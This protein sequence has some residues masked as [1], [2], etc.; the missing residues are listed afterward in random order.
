V[1]R[2]LSLF[3][4]ALFLLVLPVLTTA[5]ETPTPSPHLKQ[6]TADEY[7]T[8]IDEII[9]KAETNYMEG[10][11]QNQMEA[12]AELAAIFDEVNW[13]YLDQGELSYEQ[14][15]RLMQALPVGKSVGGYSELR[16]VPIEA[17]ERW[18]PALI[19]RWLAAN[20]DVLSPS[21]S[22]GVSHINFDE[23]DIVIT[24][25]YTG[26]F[27]D[28]IESAINLSSRYIAV[29]NSDR[30]WVVPPL[31]ESIDSDLLI[32]DDLNTDGM[33]DFAYLHTIHDGNS[34]NMGDLVVVSWTG[35]KFDILTSLRYSQAPHTMNYS[36]QFLNIDEDPQIEV[37]QNQRMYDTF[38]CNS[39]HVT[40]FD[41]DEEQQLKPNSK[42]V[43]LP[44]GFHCLLRKAEEAVW[45]G[46]YI[47]AIEVYQQ[48]LSFPTE[49]TA[50]FEFAQMRLA[51]AYLFTGDAEKADQI[52]NSLTPTEGSL[53]EVAQ[54]AYQVDHRPLAVCQA[55]YNAAIADQS[56]IWDV[57]L[58]T[59]YEVDGGFYG[60]GSY[61]PWIDVP[62][63][64]CDL[65]G[66]IRASIAD[67]NFPTTESPLEKL[68]SLGLKL[69]GAGSADFDQDGDEEW[70]VW[71]D[72]IGLSS[73]L[74]VPDG[75]FY[76]LNPSPDAENVLEPSASI[77][78]P[79]QYNQYSVM[80]LPD[81]LG[82]ALVNIDFAD[83]PYSPILCVF[84]G[85]GPVV[86]CEEYDRSL[87]RS[88]GNLTLFRV[89]NGQF[90]KF[91]SAPVCSLQPMGDSV[92]AGD[93]ISGVE[94]FTAGYGFS[95][96]DSAY[97]Y[98]LYT[99]KDVPYHWDSELKTFIP[100]LPPT[101]T[102]TPFPTPTYVPETPP[103]QRGYEFG[104]FTFPDVRRAFQEN[105]YSLVDAIAES[106]LTNDDGS[107]PNLTLAYRYYRA[108][109]LE[110]QGNLEAALEEYQLIFETAPD[111]AWG[112]L[113]GIHITIN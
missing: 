19:E 25:A 83:D 92:F 2:K 104:A 9:A 41:W 87:P 50:R 95:Q 55:L 86:T 36:W 68:E 84:C 29:S 54:Q 63:A 77:R 110:A 21:A 93:V 8:R 27:L 35:E 38:D 111:S 67:T 53:A 58:G 26:Y 47:E 89:E 33:P 22:S 43:L 64:S 108:L 44:A 91:F 105:D 69:G 78:P 70:L 112:M 94:G 106:A 28:V 49:D 37:I 32:A 12:I 56:P 66:W 57:S 30:E 72:S 20:P 46:N 103:E 14:M 1:F 98:G 51:L 99:V 4:F 101:P 11:Y 6:P 85:G 39:I 65:H 109:S 15:G 81:G 88:S 71:I 16:W 74:F 40:A 76:I 31:P 97:D 3:L 62:N 24:P 45:A 100:Q 73:I 48:A 107:D 90:V 52:F 80:T 79:N 102:A 13:R 42:E 23:T 96:N 17:S 75:E 59:L 34:Y 60:A 113:A 18:L 82:K 10:S 7:L 61:D 5:Q